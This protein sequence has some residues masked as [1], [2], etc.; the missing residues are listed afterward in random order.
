VG[1]TAQQEILQHGGVLEQLDVLEGARDAPPGDLVRRHARDVLAGEDQPAAGRIVD[2]RDEVE[3]RR[4]AGAVGAD[5]REHL[6]LLDGEAHPVEGLDAAEVDLEVLGREER[7]R[8]RSERM[9]AFWRR[10]VACL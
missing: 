6:P 4:L 3:D 8:R 2:A 1:V 9:Y 7:H 5:D 10:K